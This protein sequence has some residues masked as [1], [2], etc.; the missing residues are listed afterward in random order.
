VYLYAKINKQV[1]NI[2]IGDVV[3]IKGVIRSGAEYDADLD[4]I[5]HVIIEKSALVKE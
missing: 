2:Q 4:L 3:R 5:E 1:E